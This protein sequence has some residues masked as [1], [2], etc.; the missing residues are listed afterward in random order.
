ML[1]RPEH[2]Q[3]I[4]NGTKTETRRD[5]KRRMAKVG[6]EYKVKK[7]MLSKE[8]YAT[9][10]CT[11]LFRQ[12]LGDMTEQDAQAEG[13]YTLKEYK[14]VFKDIYGFWDDNKVLYVIRFEY[15]GKGNTPVPETGAM[16]AAR[17]CT[18]IVR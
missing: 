8:Y 3:M 9:I 5:W 10:K 14:Q 7:T 13:G 12:R 16:K 2:I 11:T 18:N 15:V 4:L 1:F 6:G 17:K